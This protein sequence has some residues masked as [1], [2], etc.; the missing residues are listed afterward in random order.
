MVAFETRVRHGVPCGLKIH[1]LESPGSIP[2]VLS[3]ALADLAAPGRRGSTW[4]FQIG[5]GAFA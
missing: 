2:L 5:I 4:R 3:P 1:H